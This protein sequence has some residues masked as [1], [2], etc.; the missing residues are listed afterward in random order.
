[1]RTFYLILIVLLFLLAQV[2][3]APR[4]RIGSASPDFVILIVVFFSLYRGPIRGA[5][6]GFVIGLL[7]DLGNPEMLGLNAMIKAALGFLLGHAGT[8]TVSDNVLFLAGLFFAAVFGHDIVYLLLYHWPRVGGAL[9][10]IFTQA[11]PAA[12][13]TTIFGVIADVLMGLLGAKAVTH[14]GK[15]GQR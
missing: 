1:M 6:F 8:K 7:Q 10:M 14:L 9:G 2:V 4:I 5:I 3:L 11:L 15:Q 12:V 13:Y